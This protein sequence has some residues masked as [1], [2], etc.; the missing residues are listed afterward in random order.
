MMATAGIAAG[1]KMVS[2]LLKVISDVGPEGQVMVISP[3][4]AMR[5][6][7]E[8]LVGSVREPLT[9]ISLTEK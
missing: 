2:P 5:M 8:S 6:R 9:S 1:I 3:S 4:M 7:K